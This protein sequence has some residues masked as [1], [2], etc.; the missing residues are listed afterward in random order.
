MITF[1][2]SFKRFL[3]ALSMILLALFVVHMTNKQS[4]VFIT[5]LMVDMKCQ[6][7]NKHHKTQ[8]YAG[9]GLTSQAI[10]FT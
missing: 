4:M 1:F 7:L 9:F 5:A 2:S 6:D 10:S 8:T 3:L